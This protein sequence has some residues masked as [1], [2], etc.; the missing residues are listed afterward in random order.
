MEDTERVFNRK[1]IE[2][3]NKII[4]QQ[5]KEL[6]QQQEVIREQKEML[7]TQ[8]K[9]LEAIIDNIYEEIYIV[10]NNGDYI[11]LNEAAK[12]RTCHSKINMYEYYDLSGNKL[13][14]NDVPITKLMNGESFKNNR[15]IEYNLSKRY[16]SI[17]AKPIFDDK[18]NFI[19][20]IMFFRDITS[21]I[22]YK[23][24]IEMQLEM[25]NKLI[26]NLDLP[27]IRLYYPDLTIKDI[28]QKRY[29]ILKSTKPEIES[30]ND[31]IGKKYLD[32]ITDTYG[33]DIFN[34]IH[35]QIKEKKTAYIKHKKWMVLGQEMFV[36]TL[37]QPIAGKGGDVEELI[38]VSFDIT[39]EVEANTQMQK[40]LKMQEEFFTNI[41]HE[42][43]TPLNV[44]YSTIQ[45]FNMYFKNGSLEE[46]KD[47]VMN[48]INTITQN[49]YR[50]SKLINNIVDISKIE[51]GFYELNLSNNNIVEVVEDIVM[52]VTDYTTSKGLDIIFD[53]D[54]E[55]KIIACDPEKIERIILNLISNA[56]KFTEKG[57]KICV[58]I[59]DKDKFVEISVCD[60]GIGID[61]NHL[62]LI[63]DRFKQVDKS[64]SRNAEGTGIGLSLVK[65]IVELH[66]G[67][68]HV[69]SEFGKGSKFTVKLPVRKVTQENMLYSS[70][71]GNKNESIKVEL[72]DISS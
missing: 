1:Y 65:S 43:K 52:S 30:L 8:K 15:I 70:K 55:E 19:M 39:S 67:T 9:Q 66:G 28:N 36:T 24:S 25:L 69:E 5:K 16:L 33:N 12:K 53:T 45:L 49:C 71:M 58:D 35:E 46:K 41:S 21:H 59:R 29:N 72:S 22:L 31:I 37:F 64:L 47:S 62:D 4:M 27:V 42:L 61:S 13:N 23:E 32:V 6:Q 54:E 26:D 56:I 60:N 57:G 68:I 11:L 17:N 18:G 44:I 10:D 38:G 20:G 40:A 7:K 14:K 48:Y 2:Q 50:L 3:Q 63:F 34:C 51:A